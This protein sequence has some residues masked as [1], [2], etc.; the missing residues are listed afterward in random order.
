MEL[1]RH[2]IITGRNAD[3][4][5]YSYPS[6]C[7]PITK[8]LEQ[9][10]ACC[11]QDDTEKQQTLKKESNSCF[12]AVEGK[13]VSYLT[14]DIQE[15]HDDSQS[16]SEFPTIDLLWTTAE[17]GCCNEKTCLSTKLN[18]KSKGIHKKRI[19]FLVEVK[20]EFKNLF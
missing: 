8:H 7:V 5:K 19:D 9:G 6:T 2:N 10:P 3:T 15:I 14:K 12:N 16:Q 1:H 4:R 18:F 13:L 17:V 11:R 20:N